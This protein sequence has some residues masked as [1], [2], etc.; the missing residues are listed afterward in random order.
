MDATIAAALIS[1]GVGALGIV[2]T[3]VT[4]VVGSKNTREATERTVQ[5][6]TENTRATLLADREQRLWERRAAAYED[7]TAGLLLR[8]TKRQRSVVVYP[9]GAPF[10]PQKLREY[11]DS[12]EVPGWNEAQARLV[13]Y[14]SREVLSAYNACQEADSEVWWLHDQWLGMHEVN[15]LAAEPG[16]PERHID[17]GVLREA[18]DAVGVA[19][20][21][22]MARE[23]ALIDLI[24][25][26][27]RSKPE[28]ATAPPA[29]PARRRGFLHRRKAVED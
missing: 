2:G 15:R 20:S 24:R 27:L 25:D 14:A 5:A 12:Q 4:S 18:G 6:G 29:L 3:V 21:T 10:D 8:Q 11:R 7:A 1:G 13:P 19:V 26:E 23:Q 16:S 22:A 9:A 28:A 17:D